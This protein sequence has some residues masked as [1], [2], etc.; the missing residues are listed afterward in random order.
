LDAADTLSTFMVN[1]SP[2]TVRFQ[3]AA[4]DLILRAAKSVNGK[5][6]RVAACGE[7]A[8]LLWTQ[9]NMEAAIRVEHL[10][11]EI[12][13]TQKVDILCCYSL[14]SF[15]GGVGSYAFEKICSAHSAVHSR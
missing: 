5:P 9:G 15:Q 3:K 14:S 6:A 11:D 7:C 8:P 2:D 12:A 10:W 13:I 1:D 4:S